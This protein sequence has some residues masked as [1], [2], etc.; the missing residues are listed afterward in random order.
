MPQSIPNDAISKIAEIL[1]IKSENE[2]YP[3]VIKDANV[4]EGL[5]L[6]Y[7]DED[8]VGKLP[9]DSKLRELRGLIV[10]LPLGKIVC[11][12]F[13]YVPT[14][15]AD[16]MESVNSF[17]YENGTMK[18]ADGH[19]YDNSLFESGYN[20]FSG[21]K[22]D[23]SP[24]YEGTMV[25]VWSH[26]GELMISTHKKIDCK[27]SHWGSS[28]K[29]RDLFEKCIAGFDLKEFTP[30]DTIHYFVLLDK[31]LQV[32]SKLQLDDRSTISMYIGTNNLADNSVSWEL[33]E[34]LSLPSIN[35]YL[36]E[37]NL[38]K[39]LFGPTSLSNKEDVSKILNQGFYNTSFPENHFQNLG[40]GFVIS[41]FRNGKRALIRVISKGFHRRS[42]IVANSP[43]VLHRAYMLLT[44]CLFPKTGE[45]K[46]I[47]EFPPIPVLDD[48]QI[49]ALKTPFVGEELPGKAYSVEELTD[50]NGKNVY[51]K[52][53]RNAVTWYAFSLALPHQL[54][55]LACIKFILYEREEVI[56]ILIRN[57]AKFK[58]G[59]FEELVF[60]ND[61]NT[62]KHIQWRLSEAEKF[63]HQYAPKNA[64]KYELE[65]LLHKNIRKGFYRDTG[66]WCFKIARLLIKDR[67]A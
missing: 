45:D 44:K 2:K 30:A 54:G 29:F 40:E 13:G 59:D 62:M 23:V 8:E 7:Y 67:Y 56:K 28:G 10:S 35:D 50:R 41:Y 5:Y 43:N 26:L 55:A 3:F 36:E 32:A 16:S 17:L 38:D 9:L 18:D 39:V 31:D 47:E 49:A 20:A 63:T 22:I 12:S 34:K 61:P 11:N 33:N 65:K 58:S 27:N 4:E 52:R 6:I 14:I 66:E 53:F 64:S 19:S 15:V 37:K 24:I 48:E 42:A 46:Y 60:K 1:D 21:E 51:E 25:R 57:F